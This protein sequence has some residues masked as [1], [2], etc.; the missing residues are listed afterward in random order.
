[1]NIAIIRIHSFVDLITNSSSELFILD[2]KQA[3][4]VVKLTIAMLAD[5]Y[6]EC[7][8]LS[9]REHYSSPVSTAGLFTDVFSEPTTAEFSFDLSDYPDQ[10]EF[11]SMQAGDHSW[12]NEGVHPIKA[13]ANHLMEVW[14]RDNPQPDYEKNKGAYDDW[15]KLKWAEAGRVYVKWAE[16]V[17]RHYLNL[18][19]WVA[20]QNGVD[21]VPLGELKVRAG[22]YVRPYYGKDEYD[23]VGD[24][25]ANRFI[26]EVNEALSW[27][28]S[29]KKGDIFLQS[30]SDNTVPYEFWPMIEN[31][32]N[33]QRMHLG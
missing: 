5:H 31:T 29:F 18:Y 24:T 2:T 19:T 4:D 15:H 11:R 23:K 17:R 26:E 14:V 20:Q 21:L 32:F 13:E 6:N 30:A 3:V 27:D 25:P 10:K 7:V 22:E 16:F 1:M 8:E 28:Y 12:N 33:T 9:D